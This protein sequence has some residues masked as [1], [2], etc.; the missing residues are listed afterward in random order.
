MSQMEGNGNNETFLI[1]N[2]DPRGPMMISPEP[3]RFLLKKRTWGSKGDVLPC[4][5]RAGGAG[6]SIGLR[7][8]GARC[9]PP[10]CTSPPSFSGGPQPASKSG[11]TGQSA[12]CPQRSRAVSGP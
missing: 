8:A 7:P 1:G 3:P 5:P 9:L 12:A 11:C 6:S 10:C 2:V 4:R